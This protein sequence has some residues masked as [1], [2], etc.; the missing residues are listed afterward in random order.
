[1]IYLLLSIAVIIIG[2]IVAIAMQPSEFVVSRSAAISAPAA[3]LFAQVNDF[4]NWEGWSPWIQL[5]PTAKNAYAGAPSGEGAIFTWNGN[6]KVGAGKMT[7]LESRP[8]TL[9]KIKL[10]FFKPFK[11]TNTA[12]FT[13]I[14]GGDLTTVTWSMS[15]KNNFMAKAFGMVM[16]CDK[17]IG[18]MFDKGLVNLQDATRK[19]A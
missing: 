6:S 8:N 15:G 19:K 16:D 7:L 5:D 13:F 17:I 9:I 3:A 11:A 12:Q 4:H 10:E 18:T 14:P 1:M 2:L